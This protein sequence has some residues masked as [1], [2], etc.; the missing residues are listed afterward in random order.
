[1]TCGRTGD[2]G[3]PASS[4]TCFSFGAGN[5]VVPDLFILALILSTLSHREVTVMVTHVTEATA[6]SMTFSGTLVLVMTLTPNVYLDVATLADGILA[7]ATLRP[8]VRVTSLVCWA[9][10]TYLYK[11]V[12][13]PL[14]LDRGCATHGRATVLPG[15]RHLGDRAPIYV[16]LTLFI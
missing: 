16:M 15:R 6:D 14:G 4:L 12:A 3:R 11:V 10:A 1:M 9:C 5:R 2:K 13:G 7:E 8:S